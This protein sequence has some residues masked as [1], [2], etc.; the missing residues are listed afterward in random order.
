[1]SKNKTMCDW[2]K[3]DIEKDLKLLSRMAD[4]PKYIC[5]KC[6]RVANS[7]EHLCK[8][9]RMKKSKSN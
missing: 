1:M 9:I 5:K 7:S 8:P 2:N 4:N 3:E 6:A